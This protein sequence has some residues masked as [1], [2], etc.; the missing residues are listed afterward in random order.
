MSRSYLFRYIPKHSYFFHRKRNFILHLNLRF[1]IKLLLKDFN[2]SINAL[3]KIIG[4]FLLKYLESNL[5][6]FWFFN[7]LFF[8]TSFT[9]KCWRCHHFLYLTLLLRSL[10]ASISCFIYSFFRRRLR[11][12]LLLFL[13]LALNHID[14]FDRIIYTFGLI[15]RKDHWLCF[16]LICFHYAAEHPF[17]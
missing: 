4:D 12:C 10:I 16:F 1:L 13:F 8:R 15:F 3:L 7:L 14:L 2:N 5:N 17:K 11:D 9:L 6:L